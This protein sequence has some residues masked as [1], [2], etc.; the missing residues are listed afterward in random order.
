[1][2]STLEAAVEAAK[3]GG[4]ILREQLG[5]AAVREKGPADLVTDADFASQAAIEQLLTSRFPQHVFLGE[6]SDE[7]DREAAKASGKPM[8]VVDPLDG[9]A[10]FAHGLPGFSVSIALLENN[11]PTVGVVYDPLADA[12]YCATADGQVT[13]N[14]KSI[15]CSG[16]EDISK[17]MVCCSFRPKVTRNH[18]EVDQFLC[19]LEATQS[20]R[21]LGSAAMNMCY[22]AE[23]CLDA[24]WASVIKTWDVAAGALIARNAGAVLTQVD[25]SPFDLWYPRFLVSGSEVLHQ[26]MMECLK[27]R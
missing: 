18:P 6:E 19:V 3:L 20:L 15:A 27:P 10:N 9:T 22:V 4:K 23:G 7:S 1:M 25:G 12:L 14:G 26:E 2:Q 8:W 13:K 24:Y 21:R 16:C 11:E 17:A 5:K